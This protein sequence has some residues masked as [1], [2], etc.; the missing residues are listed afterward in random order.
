MP[1][2]A[3]RNKAV[4]AEA[5]AGEGEG[6]HPTKQ[7]VIPLTKTEFKSLD[8]IFTK[9]GAADVAAPEAKEEEA[10][11]GG[12]EEEYEEDFE[13]EAPSVEI[14]SSS[15]TQ[16][17][18]FLGRHT[19]AT[20][21]EGKNAQVQP[22]VTYTVLAGT[23]GLDVRNLYRAHAHEKLW[24][25]TSPEHAGTLERLPKAPCAL[26]QL[27]TGIGITTKILIYK[28][29]ELLKNPTFSLGLRLE[30]KAGSTNFVIATPTGL[31]P[32]AWADSMLQ[33]LTDACDNLVSEYPYIKMWTGL[34]ES[35]RKLA[36]Y[37]LAD[38]S[39]SLV[40]QLHQTPA[41]K[42]RYVIEML[43]HLV[44]K[45]QL[46]F[47]GGTPAGKALTAKLFNA[48]R[49][50]QLEDDAKPKTALPSV[51]RKAPKQVHAEDEDGEETAPAPAPL[52]EKKAPESS[53]HLKEYTHA[54]KVYKFQIPHCVRNQTHRYTSA[55][56]PIHGY[57]HPVKSCPALNDPEQRTK[58]KMRFDEIG[59]RMPSVGQSYE[60]SSE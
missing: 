3:G 27:D 4:E 26:G 31:V 25:V 18:K 9:L 39:R 60:A 50:N 35:T 33:V 10:D 16:L 20:S 6:G 22:R 49:F 1:P 56:C 14:V 42:S 29:N 57:A 21:I 30:E 24:I 41:L 2:R 54:G 17:T 43:R 59:G 58:L 51:P 5:E 8:K 52:P 55:E 53:G 7:V 12:E 23:G 11:A 40:D 34:A 48:M 28:A 13:D 45:D 46:L 32:A 15:E 19:G 38:L 44:E 47:P 37:W 36:G